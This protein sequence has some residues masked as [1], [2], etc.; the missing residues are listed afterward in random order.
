LILH[1]GFPRGAI[2]KDEK[3]NEGGGEER[4]DLMVL[5]DDEIMVICCSNPCIKVFDRGDRG[6]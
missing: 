3:L 1:P 2:E 6:E 5:Q 4:V